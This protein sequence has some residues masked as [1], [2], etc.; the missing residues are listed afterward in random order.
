MKK[1]ILLL[2]SASVIFVQGC[3]ISQDNNHMS[4]VDEKYLEKFVEGYDI[5]YKIPESWT[6]TEIEPWTY[7]HPDASDPNN[8]LMVTY[9]EID[10]SQVESFESS[11]KGF[12]TGVDSSETMKRFDTQ[13]LEFENIKGTKVLYIGAE[14]IRNGNTNIMSIYA[15]PANKGLVSFWFESNPRSN[16][17]Y[18][19]QYRDI[20]DSIKADVDIKYKNNS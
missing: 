7:Y 3:T 15:I 4:S 8:M 2:L 5:S 18:H 6:I 17:D 13:I 16:I 12:V 1:I 11:C 9:E 19:D 10:L 14:H 20:L